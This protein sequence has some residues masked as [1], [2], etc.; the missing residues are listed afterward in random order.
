MTAKTALTS[1]ADHWTMIAPP[2]PTL[3]P[4]SARRCGSFIRRLNE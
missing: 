4:P 3:A 1:A 2:S